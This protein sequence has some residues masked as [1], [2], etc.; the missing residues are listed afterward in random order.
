DAYKRAIDCLKPGDVVILTTPPAFRWVMFKYAIE[1]GVNVFMEKPTTVDGHSTKKMLALGEEAAKKNLKVGV[2]L[3]C[4]HCEARQELYNRIKD[5]E[6]GDVVLLQ[7]YRMQGPIAT[8]FSKPKPASVSE[9]EYQIRRFH[10]FI[11]A[12]GGCYSY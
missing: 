8:E 9:L 2:G 10:S 1:K 11:W 12:S 4:R 3:M 7:A 6:I 5:G